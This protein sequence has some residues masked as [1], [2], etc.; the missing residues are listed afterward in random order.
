MHN[1]SVFVVDFI[2]FMDKNYNKGRMNYNY[3]AKKLAKT[4]VPKIIRSM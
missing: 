4:T 3:C 2:D 1:N